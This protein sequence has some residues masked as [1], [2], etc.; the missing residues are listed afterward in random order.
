MAAAIPEYKEDGSEGLGE[1][2]TSG[3]GLRYTLA[4]TGRGDGPARI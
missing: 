2:A 3:D 4:A 1:V